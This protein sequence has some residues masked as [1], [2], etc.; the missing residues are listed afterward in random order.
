MWLAYRQTITD[1]IVGFEAAARGVE[2]LTGTAEHLP[3]GDDNFDHAQVVTT[4]CFVDSP[5]QMLSE[6]RRVLRP[7]GRLVIGFIDRESELG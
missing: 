3:F 7:D 6:A 2:V 5:E 4:I 1:V